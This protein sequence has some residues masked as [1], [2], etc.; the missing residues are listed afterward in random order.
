MQDKYVK[1]RNVPPLGTDAELIIWSPITQQ[2]G[3]E[4]YSITLEDWQL[5]IIQK[6]LGIYYDEKTHSL[7]ALTEESVKKRLEKL[8]SM[9]ETEN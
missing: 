6:V 5:E 2:D 7:I 4:N 9:S 1:L 3:I 8:F